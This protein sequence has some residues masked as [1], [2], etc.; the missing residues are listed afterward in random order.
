MSHLQQFGWM[1]N[2]ACDMDACADFDGKY[3]TIVEF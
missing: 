2:E 1:I 3:Q